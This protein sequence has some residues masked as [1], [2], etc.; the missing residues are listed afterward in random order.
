MRNSPIILAGPSAAGKST[1]ARIISQMTG[2][3]IYSIRNHYNSYLI[4]RF[5]EARGLSNENMTKELHYK[6]ADWV[7]EK[8]RAAYAKMFIND[9]FPP[10]ESIFESFRLRG[11]LEYLHNKYPSAL[12]IHV[13]AEK[14]I[15]L[16]RKLKI[17]DPLYSTA[18]SL[19]KIEQLLTYEWEHFKLQDSMNYLSQIGAVMLD[20][21]SLEA[22]DLSLEKRLSSI[23]SS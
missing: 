11:D 5:L 8:D 6:A 20:T 22:D 4:P 18:K 10:E 17:Q 14:E 15:R 12:F 21:S 7:Y 1:V 16:S 13:Y 3:K 2:Y 9:L 23:M 19:Q